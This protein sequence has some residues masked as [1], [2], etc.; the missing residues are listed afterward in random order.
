MPGGEVIQTAHGLAQ[1]QQGL[2]QIGADKTGAACDQPGSGI[3][4]KLSANFV[5]SCRHTC[6]LYYVL[7]TQIRLIGA[8]YIFQ[9]IQHMFGLA[10]CTNAISTQRLELIMRHS[11]NHCIVSALLWLVCHADTVFA[12]G[13]FGIYPRIVDINVHVV[14]VEYSTNTT[15]TLMSTIL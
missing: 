14:F 15:W 13:F 3:A 2:N 5:K 10:Q 9:V 1:T 12:R 11:Q 6:F 8:E 7:K 4:L